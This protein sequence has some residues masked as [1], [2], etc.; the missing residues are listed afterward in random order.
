MELST[1]LQPPTKKLLL[2]TLPPELHLK[3]FEVLHPV[4]S[5][6]LSLTCKKFYSIYRA[7]HGTVNLDCWHISDDGK[8]VYALRHLL[9]EFKP[10]GT[11]YCLLGIHKWLTKE[12]YEECKEEMYPA[13]R[14]SPNGSNERTWDIYRPWVSVE[15]LRAE[16]AE[17]KRMVDKGEITW[18]WSG[19]VHNEA[20]SEARK[21]T[22]DGVWGVNAWS[23]GSASGWYTFKDE[24]KSVAQNGGWGVSRIKKNLTWAQVAA[25]ALR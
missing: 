10:Q 5:T 20:R 3:L 14:R 2:T 21:S 25:G 12:R 16:E 1:D 19:W 18:T 7:I 22:R 6:C 23:S 4:E 17:W 24:E 8:A 13:S 15:Q 9:P 11:Y